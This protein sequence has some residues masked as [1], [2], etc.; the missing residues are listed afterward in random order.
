MIGC[1]FLLAC[2]GLVAVATAAERGRVLFEDAAAQAGLD[3][4]HFIGATGSYYTPEIM[5]SGA[6]LLDYDGDGDLD[7]YLVQGAMLDPA[8][9]L[10]DS[11]FPVPRAHWPGNR[12]FRNELVP[13]GKL[14]FTDVTETAGVAGNGAY[15]MGVAVGDY[16]NDGDPDLFITNHGPNIL[17]R[18]N[19]GGAFTDVTRAV[20][21]DGDAFHASAAFLDYDRDGFLD[22]FVTR[23]NAFTVAGNKKCYNHAG[24]R[25]YC[26]P[27]DYFPLTNKL[28][29]NDRGR[30]MIDVTRASGIGAASGNNLGVIACDF[31][32][33]GWIDIYVA[34]DKTPNQL[35]INRR[36]GTFEDQ[37]LFAGAA[38]NADGKALA[39]MGVTAADFDGD[40]DDDIFVTNLTEETNTLYQSDGKGS[41]EDATHQFGAGYPSLPYTGFGVLWFDYDNDGRLDVFVANGEVRAVDLLR[42]TPFPY[43]QK[44]QLYRNE[45]GRLR[46][47]SAEAGPAFDLVEVSRAAAFGDI[48]NDG[49]IDIVVTNANGPVRLLLNQAG[50]RNHWLEVRAVGDGRNRDAAGGRIALLRAGRPPAW[51]RIA[52][53]G[54]Y[55]SAH[56]ARVH[57]GLGNDGEIAAAPIE[58]ILVQ[59]PDGAAERWPIEGI[60]RLITLQRGTGLPAAQSAFSKL[61]E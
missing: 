7:V 37:A 25:E 46:E 36:N 50:S 58:E 32:G 10:E 53:D 2:A 61:D 42:G 33:D 28:Y 60:D 31:N 44:N 54:S 21:I 27:G 40:G 45:G 57:F 12:L 1:R 6:A 20:G 30:R 14:R 11:M 38:Y 22:L 56:D 52:T 49:D 8:R 39:G 5:G 34:A 59:W 17:Y 35:W 13:S 41:F 48:D 24:G 23:Y 18:N 47:T 9:S 51:R 55:L 3:F 43:G 16:D 19:G 29:R 4:Q 26:G 15:G